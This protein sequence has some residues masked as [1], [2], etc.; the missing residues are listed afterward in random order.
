MRISTKRKITTAEGEPEGLPEATN[1]IGVTKKIIC[2]K[3]ERPIGDRKHS[4]DRGAKTSEKRA[5]MH[6][7][8][9]TNAE[10]KEDRLEQ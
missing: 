3:G 7:L 1:S 6:K 10:R 9:K 5:S 2:S 4:G 8:G